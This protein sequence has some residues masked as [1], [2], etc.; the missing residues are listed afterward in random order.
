MVIFAIFDTKKCPK[1]L[2]NICLNILRIPSFD[3]GTI[4]NKT[5]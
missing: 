5:S 4:T 3:K 1:N 2:N